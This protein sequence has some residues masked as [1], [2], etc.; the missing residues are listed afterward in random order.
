MD[1]FA[2]IRTINLFL[3][4][5]SNEKTLATVKGVRSSH[6][7]LFKVCLKIFRTFCLRR[8]KLVF[9]GLAPV[10]PWT[11]FLEPHMAKSVSQ[12]RKHKTDKDIS[13]RGPS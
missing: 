9:P 12:K 3:R 7:T 1:I 5:C 6:L 4:I 11:I 8:L 13:R 2:F 10:I